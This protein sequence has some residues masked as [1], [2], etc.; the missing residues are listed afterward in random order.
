MVH[1]IKQSTTQRGEIVLLEMT[2]RLKR[3]IELRRIYKR[4]NKRKFEASGIGYKEDLAFFLAKYFQG[5][6]IK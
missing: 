1:Y 2:K 4:E 3:A 5:Q 6:I